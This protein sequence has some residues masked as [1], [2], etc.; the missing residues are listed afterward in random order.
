MMKRTFAL[1]LAFMLAMA[2]LAAVA[3][4]F[5]EAP[6]TVLTL[7]NFSVSMLDRGRAKAVR[8]KGMSLTMTVGSANAEVPTLLVTFDNG[9]G[10]LVDLVFQVA[11][12]RLLA[13]AGGVSGTY[14]VDLAAVSGDPRD[15]EMLARGLRNGLAVAGPNLAGVLQALSTE[16]ATGLRTVEFILPE[17]V[18]APVARG[19]LNIAGVLGFTKQRDLDAMSQQLEQGGGRA[20]VIIRYDQNGAFEL[21]AV[22]DG[23]GV[24]LKGDA[25]LTVQP[26][27]LVNISADEMMYDLLHLNFLQLNELRGELAIVALKFG[28]FAGGTGLSRIMGD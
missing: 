3:E 17:D 24:R 6:A 27:N 23:S 19:I 22:R 8:M 9:K 5:A 16:D 10:Q 15:G 12:E 13:S 14:Y 20:A 1:V 28:H 25:K 11:G 18:Y 21:D 26:M 4:P 2:S 7:D